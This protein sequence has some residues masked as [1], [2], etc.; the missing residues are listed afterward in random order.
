MFYFGRGK[1][2]EEKKLN[3]MFHWEYFD[4][5]AKEIGEND[6]INA[7]YVKLKKDIDE[8]DEL[9]IV[10]IVSFSGG[11]VGHPAYFGSYLKFREPAQIRR[12]EPEKDD[13]NELKKSV[14][15]LSQ[16]ELNKL[17]HLFEAFLKMKAHIYLLEIKD[18][19]EKLDLIFS[20]VPGLWQHRTFRTCLDQFS[21]EWTETH[22][23]EKVKL[24][25]TL[26][27]AQYDI[28]DLVKEYKIRYNSTNRADIA[29]EAETS[30]QMIDNFKNNSNGKTEENISFPDILDEEIEEYLVELAARFN[31][32]YQQKKLASKSEK[33]IRRECHLQDDLY[34]ELS[35]LCYKK[36]FEVK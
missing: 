13:L 1:P 34:F 4:V 12:I 17:D 14:I 6:H 2:P 24:L 27:L 7:V 5:I 15:S 30:L 10:C 19:E 11:F 18:Y 21:Y 8:K 33:T 9:S 29:N 3:Y 36:Y 20:K 23:A 28:R 26:K 25:S 32:F 35:G 22:M 16:K 31:Y